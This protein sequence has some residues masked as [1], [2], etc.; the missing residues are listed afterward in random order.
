[1]TILMQLEGTISREEKYRAL[2]T[3][4]GTPKPYV[5]LTIFAVL[6]AVLSIP[7]ILKFAV[8][9]RNRLRH[10]PQYRPIRLLWDIG[11]SAKLDR[12]DRLV[13]LHLTHQAGIK[14][15]ASVLLSINLFDN[16]VKKATGHST[17]KSKRLI[18]IR[19]RLFAQ[20]LAQ[21]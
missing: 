11:N 18:R 14:H 16:A 5:L 6:F 21:K 13:L 15:P 4:F 2:H 10:E 8:Y 17:P 20:T 1:M 3:F 12:L 7:L 9:L 19:Q